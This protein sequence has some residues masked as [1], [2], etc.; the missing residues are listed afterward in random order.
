MLMDE[1]TAALGI[2]EAGHVYSLMRQL[3]A[4]GH[5]VLVVSHNLVSVFDIA[6]RIVVLRHG[7]VIANKAVS[8]VTRDEIVGLIVGSGQHTGD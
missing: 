1:P 5:A 7:R 6:D 8:E 3:R 4:D 2:R